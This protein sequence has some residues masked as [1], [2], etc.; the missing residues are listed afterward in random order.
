MPDSINK[1]KS[2]PLTL[3]SNIHT[4][5]SLRYLLGSSQTKTE[6]IIKEMYDSFS[7]KTKYL[8][9]FKT[10]SIE[11]SRNSSIQLS[12]HYIPT[13]YKLEEI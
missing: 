12:L 3:L 4:Q 5:V 11:P 8:L 9:I 2:T 1:H 10:T 7:L 6:L 13:N